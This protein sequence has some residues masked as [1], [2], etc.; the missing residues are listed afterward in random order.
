MSLAYLNLKPVVA[1]IALWAGCS[2]AAWAQGGV[3]DALAGES[4][5]AGAVLPDSGDEASLLGALAKAGPSEARH[6]ERQLQALW[7]R[8]G[9][10]SM[11]LLAKRGREALESGETRAAIEH[12]TALTDH[13][14]DFAEGWYLRASAYFEAGLVGP[15]LADLGRALTLNPNNYEAIFGLGS[16]LESLDDIE[17]ARAAYA[18]ALAIHPHNEDA[19]RALERL[20][21]RM[22]GT[23]L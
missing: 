19:A 7:R 13:A 6:L 3:P 18:R 14:P 23:S 10:A 15:A 11:D 5:A 16:I 21:P 2:V 12:L 20:E 1:A 9:S 4:G 22:K 17:R 8:S